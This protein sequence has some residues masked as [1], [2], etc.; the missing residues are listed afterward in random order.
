MIIRSI[1]TYTTNI[2]IN[3]NENEKLFEKMIGS[4]TENRGKRIYQK[5]D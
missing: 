1:S 2:Y 4:S 5:M 3:K